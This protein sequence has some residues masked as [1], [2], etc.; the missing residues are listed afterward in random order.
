MGVGGRTFCVARKI[1]PGRD[2]IC[3]VLGVPRL[4]ARFTRQ[5]ANR[6]LAASKRQITGR[7]NKIMRKII[8]N[9]IDVLLKNAKY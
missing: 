8:V 7:I 2:Q 6:D 1:L 9:T 5:T 3:R 4:G